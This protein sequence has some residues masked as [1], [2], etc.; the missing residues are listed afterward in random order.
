MHVN[1]VFVHT[2]PIFY[3]F[4]NI[5]PI[6]TFQIHEVSSFNNT[7]QEDKDPMQLADRLCALISTNI[8]DNKDL[9]QITVV[10]KEKIHFEGKSGSHSVEP[11]ATPAHASTNSAIRKVS[12]DATSGEGE[13]TDNRLQSTPA[14][15]GVELGLEGTVAAS[16]LGVVSPEDGAI[17]SLSLVSTVKSAN[18]DAAIQQGT[19]SRPLM[20]LPE[21]PSTRLKRE[22]HI[23]GLDGVEI[24]S[25]DV[26]AHGCYLLAGCGNGMVLL[27]DLTQN[28]SEPAL[29]G[30]IMAKGL[31]T[32]LLMNVRITEDCRFCFAGVAKGSSELL[33]IDLGR[34]P[35]WGQQSV[36]GFRP[37]RRAVGFVNDRVT[38]HSRSDPKLRGFGAAV[39]VRGNYARDTYRLASGI[40]I[41][42]VHVW[43]FTPGP[44]P[45][46]SEWV[47]M[48]DVA[49]NGNTIE[50][51]GFRNGGHELYSKSVGVS[52]RV[53]DLSGFDTTPDGKPAF[54]DI[55]N[56]A[57][58]RSL[59][60]GF[61]FGGVYEFA[62][63]RLAAPK[64]ANR[65]VL[66]VPERR[67]ASPSETGDR[68]RRLMRQINNVIGTDDARHAMIL[69]AD[70]G[71]L[72]YNRPEE[73]GSRGELLELPKLERDPD[74]LIQSGAR[75][76][77][78]HRVGASGEVVLLRATQTMPVRIIISPLVT[79]APEACSSSRTADMPATAS[80]LSELEQMQGAYFRN[81]RWTEWGYY[82]TADAADLAGVEEE[83]EQHKPSRGPRVQEEDTSIAP[84]KKPS[85]KQGQGRPPLP[86]TSVASN[87]RPRPKPDRPAL[88]ISASTSSPSAAGSPRDASSSH[89][90][91]VPERGRGRPPSNSMS[92][93]TPP[94]S[95]FA[96]LNLPVNINPMMHASQGQCLNYHLQNMGPRRVL[97]P[98]DGEA[99]PFVFEDEP[100][101]TLAPLVL[102]PAK[103]IRRVIEAPF[104]S[105]IYLSEAQT[106]QQSHSQ[107]EGRSVATI[108]ME[109]FKSLCTH[110][111]DTGRRIPQ[112]I[113]VGTGGAGRADGICTLRKMGEHIAE[114]TRVRSQFMAEVTRTVARHL[115]VLNHHEHQQLLAEEAAARLEAVVCD[116][117]GNTLTTPTRSMPVAV[118]LPLSDAAQEVESVVGKYQCVLLEVLQRQEVEVVSA[119][120]ADMMTSDTVSTNPANLQQ[121]TNAAMSRHTD[122]WGSA[123]AF[124]QTVQLLVHAA[125]QCS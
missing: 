67:Q 65:D 36:S 57:D 106:Q 56:S 82:C 81:A 33:A 16:V 8:K 48:Y 53:W 110:F 43:Q 32:N 5:L 64:T 44:T 41:K 25:L 47:C 19:H 59:L 107:R 31:H 101:Q 9:K 91:V 24:T 68:R 85:A 38:C 72:Y 4:L 90:G 84:V 6:K 121:L 89:R 15:G 27:F 116:E 70:G 88:A 119:R 74:T 97:A 50:S 96:A 13:N 52:L 10:A 102:A 21:V 111:I 123:R 83:P 62:M 1:P 78:L 92:H 46:E 117:N 42:N 66:E 30:H 124:V 22:F 28:L 77:A 100:Q 17:K 105:G 7:T 2:N 80:T 79:I 122:I 76:W 37:V 73:S 51:I 60:D 103:R 118:T 109:R 58:V 98:G 40:G 61:A 18:I 125:L 104:N 86:P 75:D 23:E 95:H 69:C 87:K 29:V 35:V 45:A 71:V 108:V 54:E 3:S 39:R 94:R 63:V 26:T 49:S 114:Q 112:S 99:V 113:A 115:M 12:P 14:V 55:A 93:P 20:D 11:G 34:L 120:S